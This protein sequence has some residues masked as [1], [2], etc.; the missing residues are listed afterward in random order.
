MAAIQTISWDFL[1]RPRTQ[2]TAGRVCTL[3]LDAYVSGTLS[4]TPTA[5]ISVTQAG[6][7][8]LP[9]PIVDVAVTVASGHMTYILSAAN[10]ATLG[11]NYMA[12][13][14][15]TIG[16]VVY[17]VVQLF[18][19]VRYP[20][21]NVVTTAD[22][23]RY[24]PDLASSYFVGETSA[25]AYIEEAYVDVWQ[26]LDSK[27][28]RPYLILSPEDFRR[29]LENRALARYYD[30]RIKAPDDRW[31]RAF[32]RHQGEY[33]RWIATANFSYDADDS[34]TVDGTSQ[35]GSQAGEDG[36]NNGMRWQI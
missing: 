11:A 22:L 4:P 7:A 20:F 6:G 23:V 26:V 35:F 3:S 10:T 29:P 12:S 9:T 5:T 21:E 25:Q 28:R 30:A 31:D 16:G 18:D 15:V 1:D 14:K 13:W 33:E 19:V 27:G 24:H 8:Q 2:A 17:P 32:K 36:R 34:G